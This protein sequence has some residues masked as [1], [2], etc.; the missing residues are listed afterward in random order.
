VDHNGIA[1]RPDIDC[2]LIFDAVV[3]QFGVALVS[4]VVLEGLVDHSWNMADGLWRPTVVT[5]VIIV[6]RTAR[7]YGSTGCSDSCQHRSSLWF[8]RGHRCRQLRL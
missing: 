6:T 3:D 4:A 1:A 8:E 2:H 7:E 5:A